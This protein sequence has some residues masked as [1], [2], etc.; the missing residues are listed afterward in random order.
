MTPLGKLPQ[1]QKPKIDKP[2]VNDITDVSSRALSELSTYF[3]LTE[4][5]AQVTPIQA[6]SLA[7]LEA[8]SVPTQSYRVL[9]QRYFV[10]AAPGVGSGIAAGDYLDEPSAF[11][12]STDDGSDMNVPG[13][14]T[15]LFL[16]A[17]CVCGEGAP[18]APG[19]DFTLGVYHAGGIVGST[20]APVISLY[21]AEP[22]MTGSEIVFTSPAQMSISGTQVSSEFELP[23]SNVY[24]VGVN[25]SNLTTNNSVL[26]FSYRLTFKNV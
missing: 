21:L 11:P 9:T 16:S 17:V 25:V 4:T 22:P 10:L 3:G 5:Q 6:M 15:K 2:I 20:T 18:G 26:G 7:G 24:A 12:F 14:T 8:E 1:F 13:L 23:L 19:A